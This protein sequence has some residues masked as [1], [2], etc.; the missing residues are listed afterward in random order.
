MICQEAVFAGAACRIEIVP[1][2][3]ALNGPSYAALLYV[4]DGGDAVRPVLS[5]DGLRIEVHGSSEALALSSAIALL[6][7]RFG[8]ITESVHG[9]TQPVVSPRIAEPYVL[10][11]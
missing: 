7:S 9:C 1:R 2:P 11:E 10:G 5:R 8:A 6:E 3:Y 4:I